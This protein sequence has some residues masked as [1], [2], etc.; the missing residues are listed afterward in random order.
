MFPL[1][2]AGFQYF[3]YLKFTYNV[4]LRITEPFVFP[5]VVFFFNYGMLNLVQCLLTVFCMWPI[6]ETQRHVA[7]LLIFLDF[8]GNLKKVVNVNF[9]NAVQIK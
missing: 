3:G 4:D 1:V 5:S 7:R 8:I 9:R 2:P 6:F